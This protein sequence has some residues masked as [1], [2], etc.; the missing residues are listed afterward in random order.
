MNPTSVP[1]EVAPTA[2]AQEDQPEGARIPHQ[3][4]QRE[5]CLACHSSDG[6]APSP[7]DH[8]G[9]AV[10]SCQICHVGSDL[11]PAVI[12]HEIEGGEDCL[13]CHAMES[14]TVSVPAD[15]EDR[16][17]SLCRVCHS[18]ALELIPTAVPRS[19]M[20]AIP[21]EIA[22]K[23]QCLACHG[24]LGVAPAPDDHMGRENEACQACHVP[25][26]IE[27]PTVPHSTEAEDRC[28]I[29]HSAGGWVPYAADHAS[30]V[31]SQCLLCHDA[32]G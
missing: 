5:A 19:P 30:R 21:H 31:E 4:L 7:S 32:M 27:S 16:S 22:G 26:D 14:G 18:L 13:L 15:H 28:L 8:V 12:S 23:D 24:T 20:L 17:S 29:C 9:R 10:E 3:I 11:M 25:S 1:E 6:I 2:V